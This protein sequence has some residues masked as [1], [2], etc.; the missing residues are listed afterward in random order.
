ME[1]LRWKTLSR[2]HNQ[3]VDSPGILALE[4][5]LLFIRQD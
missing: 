4:F 1:Q 2:S 5:M 3:Y